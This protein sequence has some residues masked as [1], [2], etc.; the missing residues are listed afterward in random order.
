M[1]TEKLDCE[2]NYCANHIFDGSKDCVKQCEMCEKQE[3]KNKL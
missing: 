2:K 1:E 3:L